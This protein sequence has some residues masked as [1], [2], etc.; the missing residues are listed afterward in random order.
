VIIKSPFDNKSYS[1]YFLRALNAHVEYFGISI[2]LYRAIIDS[3]DIEYNFYQL[4][5]D[6]RRKYLPAESIKGII[7]TGKEAN[8]PRLTNSK[9]V[10]TE[11]TTFLP[12]FFK[13]TDKI[14]AGD[15]IGLDYSI[16]KENVSLDDLKYNVQ[17]VLLEVAQLI[18]YGYKYTSQIEYRLTLARMQDIKDLIIEHQFGSSSG[19]NTQ[20]G[21]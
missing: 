16:L 11:L 2:K 4:T 10:F 7:D 19:A 1:E 3:K 18:D 5:V 8:R 6:K 20:F 21:G 12:G 9:G 14:K 13:F 17:E 15:L